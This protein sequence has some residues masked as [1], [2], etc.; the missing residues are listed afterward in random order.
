MQGGS[1][2][3]NDGEASLKGRVLRSGAEAAQVQTALSVFQRTVQSGQL[4]SSL[5]PEHIRIFEEA[6]G[7]TPSIV[8]SLSSRPGCA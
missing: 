2:F 5:L 4:W 3:V 8:S 6:G 7:V 1:N